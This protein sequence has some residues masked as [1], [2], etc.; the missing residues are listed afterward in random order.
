MPDPQQSELTD[1]YFDDRLDAAGGEALTAALE[2]DEAFRNWFAQQCRCEVALRMVVRVQAED[3]TT[4]R[5]RR[6]PTRRR[7]RGVVRRARSGFLW[8]AAAAGLAAAIV[9]VVLGL[10]GPRS[11]GAAAE[12]I[13]G[14]SPALPV[15]ARL[16]DGSAVVAAAGATLRFTASGANLE[17]SAGSNGVVRSDG[18]GLER[19]RIDATVPPLTRETA[20]RIRT[21][22]ALVTVIGTRFS[23]TSDA[24]STTVAVQQGVVQVD[25]TGGM[26]R[27]HPGESGLWPAPAAADRPAITGVALCSAPGANPVLTLSDGATVDLSLVADRTVALVVA[28]IDACQAVRIQVADAQG[29]PVCSRLSSLEQIRP[30]TFPGDQSGQLS[31]RWLLLPG[32]YVVTAEAFADESG[33]HRLGSPVV[34]R[35]TVAAPR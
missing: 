33:H 20:F 35:F 24:V 11:D 1:A 9:I 7:R 26:R 32:Q 2:Q 29:N 3:V 10:A 21:P 16:R 18:L 19:G 27:L 5:H 15:G 25:G 30:F 23:V 13:A 28:T 14:T 34:V 17:L 8:A 4:G 12:V 22:H 31:E 6:P